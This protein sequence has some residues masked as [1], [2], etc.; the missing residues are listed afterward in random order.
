MQIKKSLQ[1]L[2]VVCT[3]SLLLSACQSVKERE[4]QSA[5]E[6]AGDN[7]AELQSVIDH[8]DAQPDGR[9][10][11]AARFLIC[12]MQYHYSL[13]SEALDRHFER[14]DSIDRLTPTRWS[15]SREQ[16]SLL[17]TLKMPRVKEQRKVPDTRMVKADALIRHIDGMFALYDSAVWC[18]GV[19]FETFC[20][21]LLP[22]RVADERVDLDWPQFYREKVEARAGK[23]FR[24]AATRV[25]TLYTILN[26][27]SSDYRIDI[28]YRTR[29]PFGYRPQQLASLQRGTCTDYSTLATFMFRSVGIPTAIDFVPMWG[30]RSMGHDWNALLVSPAVIDTTV[31]LDYSF[32]GAQKPL[33]QYLSSN[34]NRPTKVYRHAYSRQP[35]AL[36]V[37]AESEEIPSAFDSEF[38]VDVSAEYGLNLSATIPLPD[39]ATGHRFCYLCTFDNQ[40]WQPVAWVE[41]SRSSVT[42]SNLGGRIIYLPCVFEGGQFRS[43]APPFLLL[44]DGSIRQLVADTMR[45]Q[46]MTLYRKY[47]SGD[48]IARYSRLLAGGRIEV[49]DN[50]SFRH[51]R[52]VHR[53]ADSTS[54]NYQFIRMEKPE[55]CRCV[56][57]VAADGKFGG[58]VAD[59]RALADD[60][61]PIAARPI[62]I[63][64]WNEKHPL[65]A[66]FDGDVLSYSMSNDSCG[67]W[68]G[69]DFGALKDIGQIDILP[70]NDDN[71]IRVGERY[72]LQCWAD[73]RWRTLGE[74]TGDERQYLTFDGCP[75]GGLYRLR[76]LTK[77]REERIFTYEDGRQVWW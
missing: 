46:P 57:F 68:L 54:V 8:Y 72:Q 29:F 26:R 28:E 24:Y 67:A 2:T 59:F 35:G 53:F 23:A 71:F 6:Q 22:Y 48:N 11:L 76:N 60:G 41:K 74:Q 56:R 4:L 44:A 16:D 65:A 14:L 34:P 51:G 31:A 42:F 39:A 38:L 27:M 66:A 33:G 5:L 58:E 52:V 37:I 20:E 18:N 13:T 49:A 69:L 43:I 40:H 64:Q 25:D 63:G 47:S 19:P 21:Y 36:A 45:L 75:S 61:N 15:V 55:A 62:G 17:R 50:P 7:R 9:K 32:S 77:G 12:N 30:N 1:N 3:L 10:A 73:G 70:H